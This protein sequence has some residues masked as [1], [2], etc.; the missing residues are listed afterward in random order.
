VGGKK[1][2]QANKKSE[3][4]KN[5]QNVHSKLTKIGVQ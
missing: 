2:D 4:R 3:T 5:F 1:G